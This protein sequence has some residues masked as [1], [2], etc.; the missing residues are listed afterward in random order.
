[1]KVISLTVLVLVLTIIHK[2]ESNS[3]SGR[4]LGSGRVLEGLDK[5]GGIAVGGLLDGVGGLLGGTLQSALAGPL[6]DL[7]S[8]LGL[9]PEQIQLV[10]GG[11]SD[12]LSGLSFEVLSNTELLTDALLESPELTGLLESL[13][14]DPVQIETLLS[15]VAGVIANIATILGE[16]LNLEDVI[17]ILQQVGLSL[18]NIGYLLGLVAVVIYN[19]GTDIVC[20]PQGLLYALSTDPNVY[21][22]LTSLGLDAATITSLLEQL[23]V[24]ISSLLGP[25]YCPTA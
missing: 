1:M 14:L 5:L 22:L 11:L 4:N 15:S 25:I 12:V 8:G 16:L 3:V 23:S 17:Y 2:A 6:G 13:G 19:A 10:L 18:D 9:S 24:A 20:N 7:L 21:Y